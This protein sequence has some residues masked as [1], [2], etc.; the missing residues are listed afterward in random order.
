MNE[1]T[2][3]GWK[4]HY[5]PFDRQIINI[6][7]K[8]ELLR[9]QTEFPYLDLPLMSESHSFQFWKRMPTISHGHANWSFIKHY[10]RCT[11]TYNNKGNNELVKYPPSYEMNRGWV[12]NPF[13]RE[14]L[15]L[16]TILPFHKAMIL[17]LKFFLKIFFA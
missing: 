4:F 15:D 8:Q 2:E 6:S 16:D 5:S 14:E 1:K 9:H 11:S 10:F 13:L 3:V 12:E 17:G 7:S